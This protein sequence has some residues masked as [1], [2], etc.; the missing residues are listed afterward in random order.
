MAIER[1]EVSSLVKICQWIG[2]DKT[3][4]MAGEAGVKNPEKKMP[5][6]FLDGL[7]MTNAKP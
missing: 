6:S 4:H 1:G 5:T 7:R 3:T 2:E